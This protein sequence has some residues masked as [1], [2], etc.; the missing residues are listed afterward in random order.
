[1]ARMRETSETTLLVSFVKGEPVD[2]ISGIRSR[3]LTHILPSLL[4]DCARFQ[5]VLQKIAD[6]GVVKKSHAA[7]GMMDHKP[8]LCS[9]VAY[10][11]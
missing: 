5:A 8:F 7:I 3:T 2:K 10:T 9:Q 1:M 6:N 4:L 11:R